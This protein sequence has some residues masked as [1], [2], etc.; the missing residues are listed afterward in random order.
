MC[1]RESFTHKRWVFTTKQIKTLPEESAWYRID[2]TK[3]STPLPLLPRTLSKKIEGNHTAFN[4]SFPMAK[5]EYFK[6][7]AGILRGVISRL[8]WTTLELSLFVRDCLLFVQ[9][10]ELLLSS[11][12]SHY[13]NNEKNNSSSR[14]L[15]VNGRVPR[16]ERVTE[17]WEGWREKEQQG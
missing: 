17:C 9:C 16:W 7:R 8:F 11:G 10:L 1:K 13:G 15:C 6:G 12:P 5:N 2:R 14:A 3:S 4:S